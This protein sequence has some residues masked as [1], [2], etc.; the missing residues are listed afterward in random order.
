MQAGAAREDGQP[1]RGGQRHPQVQVV[2][3]LRLARP[4][5]VPPGQPLRPGRQ[6]PA[7]RQ[8]LPQGVRPRGRQGHVR[9]PQAHCAGKHE[10]GR[11]FR[12]R[13]DFFFLGGNLIFL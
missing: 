6:R 7:G 11:G 10:V 9:G 4:A 5:A 1:A 13:G 3:E 2:P 8:A 12:I